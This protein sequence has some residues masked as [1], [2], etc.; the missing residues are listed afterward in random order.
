M[1]LLADVMNWS[2]SLITFL[3]SLL[4]VLSRT[5]GL[6]DLG[7][8][9]DF[10]FSLGMMTVVD[11]LKCKGQYS[12]SIQALSIWIML[13]KH[14][15]SLR[16]ILKWLYD[17]L[18]RLGVEVL[19][20]FAI[21]ILNSFFENWGQEEVGLLMKSSRTSTPTWQWKAVLK[22]EWSTFHR[23]LMSWHCWLL[24]L[25]ALIVGNFLLLTWFMSSQELHFLLVISWILRSKKDHLDDLTLFLNSFQ[26]LRLLVDL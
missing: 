23:S 8:L 14:S 10:L 2:L 5:I 9:Y 26:L 24:C 12:N 7:I 4:I 18:F 19:L 11:L 17:N 21:V 25:M 13:F 15:S 22:V 20:Q 3:I 6:K 16:M 1:K